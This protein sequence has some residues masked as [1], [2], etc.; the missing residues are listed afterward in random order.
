MPITNPILINNL[1]NLLNAASPESIRKLQRYSVYLNHGLY[2]RDDKG[3]R[4]IA[5]TVRNL[6]HGKNLSL[7]FSSRLITAYEESL[8]VSH[9]KDKTILLDDILHNIKKWFSSYS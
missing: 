2:P 3:V 5:E 8:K 6:I 1:N 7:A 4:E 9:Y